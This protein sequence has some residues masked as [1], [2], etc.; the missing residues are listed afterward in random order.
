MNT[1]SSKNSA[2]LSGF[3]YFYAMRRL[4]QNFYT[5]TFFVVAL[6]FLLQVMSCSLNADGNPIGGDYSS[7]VSS[8]SSSSKL[9]SSSGGNLSSK[10]S[11]SSQS[12]P[13]SSGATVSSSSVPVEINKWLVKFTS[14]PSG[15]FVREDGAV[16]RVDSLAVFKGEVQASEYLE[17]MGVDPG[18]HKSVKNRPIESVSWSQAV[19]FCNALSKVLKLDT[20]YSFTAFDLDGNLVDLAI[21]YSVKGVRLPTEAEWEYAARATSKKL[22]SWGDVFESLEPQKYTNHLATQTP[23]PVMSRTPNIWGLYDMEGN[24]SEW[25]QD[26]YSAYEFSAEINNPKGPTFGAS[27]AYRGGAYNVEVYYRKIATRYSALPIIKSPTIGFR[28][29]L[30]PGT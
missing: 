29:V 23:E 15:S 3:E 4:F 21:D 6:F 7:V 18:Y 19:A 12:G 27:K 2:K 28:V 9:K 20:V 24:V 26:W 17:L 13:L 8:I 1:K 30:Q 5:P 16:I 25:T 10:G 14:I 22:Y 11:S